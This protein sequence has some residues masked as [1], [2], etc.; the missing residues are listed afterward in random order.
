[1]LHPAWSGMNRPE[2]LGIK[3]KPGFVTFFQNTTGF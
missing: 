1:M 2:G 3:K